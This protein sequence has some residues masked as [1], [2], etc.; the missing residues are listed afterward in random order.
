MSFLAMIITGLIV[1]LIARAIK[2]G[3]DNLGW[4]M[5]ILVGI[6]GALVAGYLGQAL[7]WYEPGEPA[8]W[9]A[10]TLGAILVLVG[11]QALMGNRGTHTRL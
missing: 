1:G 10:S 7:N 9:I 5:T 3:R 8:G 2:P 6:A 4:V 11:V